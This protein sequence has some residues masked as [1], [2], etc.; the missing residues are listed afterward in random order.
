MQEFL[1]CFTT[2]IVRKH[3]GG[4]IFEMPGITEFVSTRYSSALQQLDED[5]ESNT[6]TPKQ[7]QEQ[8]IRA[9]DMR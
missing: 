6:T 3:I 2:N 4:G 9:M 8:E 5:K 7:K 1:S